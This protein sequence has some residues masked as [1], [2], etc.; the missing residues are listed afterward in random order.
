MVKNKLQ[1]DRKRRLSPE[2]H[3]IKIKDD[4]EKTTKI[5]NFEKERL[6]VIKVMCQNLYLM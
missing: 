6:D 1:N 5:M 4:D 2:V 3:V